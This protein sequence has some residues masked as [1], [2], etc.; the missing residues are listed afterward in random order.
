MKTYFLKINFQLF[1]TL[2][3]FFSSLCISTYAQVPN[4]NVRFASPH[5]SNQTNQY[6]VNV[7]FK[8]DT[9]AVELFGMNIRF[10][11]DVSSLEFIGFSDFQSGYAAVSPDPAV[12]ITSPAGPM[13]F[14]FMD[15]A[16]W[17]NGAMQLV[18]TDTTAIL[19]DTIAWTKIFQVCFNITNPNPDMEHYCPS[20]VWDMEQDSDNGGFLN[21]DDGVVI[22]AVDPNPLMESYAVDEHVSQFNWAYM[23]NG[24]Y[25]WGQPIENNCI[26]LI[27]QTLAVISPQNKVLEFPQSTDPSSTGFA[28]ASD[29]CEGNPAISFIDVLS[30]GQCPN[31]FAIYRMWI[32][33]NSCN[34]SDTSIQMINVYD[35]T[36]P[37]LTCPQNIIVEC[38]V[39]TVAELYP[40]ATAVDVGGGITMVTSIGDVITNE[41]SASHYILTRTFMAADMCGNTSTGV[42]IIT[43]NDQTPPSIV[44]PH[45]S[46]INTFFGSGLSFI[47]LSQTEM[48]NT[49]NSFTA[50]SIT[51]NDNCSQII[52]PVFTVMTTNALSCVE[53]GYKEERVYTWTAT[54][55]NGNVT[56]LSFTIDIIDDIVPVFSGIPPDVKIFCDSLPTVPAIYADDVSTPV[57]I[58]Y[59]QTIDPANDPGYYNVLREWI[60]TDACGNSSTGRQHIYWKP[61]AIL[62]AMI[63]KPDHVICNSNKVMIT[64]LLTGA[65]EGITYAWKVTGGKNYIQSGQGT[66]TIYIYKDASVATVYLVLTDPHGCVTTVSINVDCEVPAITY[67]KMTGMNDPVT[68]PDHIEATATGPASNEQTDLSELT[69]MNLYPNP[70]S[71]VLNLNF[72]TKEPKEIELTIVNN[73]G[74]IYWSSNYASIP[75]L[76]AMAIDISQAPEGIYFLQIKSG[77]KIIRKILTVLHEI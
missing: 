58:Q 3:L 65:T 51:V 66:P 24:N 73:T 53:E 43:V 57:S 31:E 63:I 11:Y 71:D 75:G 42:Q 76:N 29:D 50:S 77:Q 44:I 21:G 72:E 1:I 9:T 10:F 12:E 40:A 23:G 38:P 17:V 62:T 5:Y 49:L 27:Q 15:S 33:T 22:T 45:Q 54:D 16:V 8:S 2:T 68:K 6:C 18:N 60:A 55:D 52:I 36:P 26:P 20:L 4:V 48:I 74:R 14:N 35:T 28:S 19:L 61:S 7:E 13:L 37:V 41:I 25:P 70:V 59:A 32:A 34:Q 46:M 67:T 69:L 64:S 30:E 47:S 56:V 39:S